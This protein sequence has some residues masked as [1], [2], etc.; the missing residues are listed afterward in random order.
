MATGFVV[1]HVRFTEQV[2][3]PDAITHEGAD[4]EI[5][6]DIGGGCT[7]MVKL[8]VALSA[9]TLA[10]PAK[11]SAKINKIVLVAF[12]IKIITYKTGCGAIK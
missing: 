10:A 11:K 3:A 9:L 12:I 8:P 5:V 4:E 1:F 7:V 2:L 6:P